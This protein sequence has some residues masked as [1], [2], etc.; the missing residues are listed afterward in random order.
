MQVPSRVVVRIQGGHERAKRQDLA[1]GCIVSVS[2]TS[3]MITFAVPV[4]LFQILVL[5]WSWE[6]S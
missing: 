5:P 6:H 3:V 1:R 2:E 4:I